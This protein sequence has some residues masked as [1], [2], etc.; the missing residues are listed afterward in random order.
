MIRKVVNDPSLSAQQKWDTLWTTKTTPWDRNTHSPALEELLQDKKFPLPHPGRP[1][2]ALVPGCGRG[3][4]VVL[5]ASLTGDGGNR[6]MQRVVGLDVSP[7]AVEEARTR[8]E[9]EIGEG[10]NIV[11][12]T[13]DFFADEDE[14]AKMGPYDVVYDYTVST[15]FASLPLFVSLSPR[16]CIF[17]FMSVLMC[18]LVRW[19]KVSSSALFLPQ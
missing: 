18:F 16:F 17:A 15:P 7:T 12:L 11:F 9:R 1:L 3:Y 14:W 2:R 10:G 8:F 19:L 6:V 4:D 13:G 5:L